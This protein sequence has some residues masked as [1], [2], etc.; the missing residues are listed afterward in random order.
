MRRTFPDFVRRY[1][2]EDAGAVAALLRE[3][4]RFHG[5]RLPGRAA[6][7][8]TLAEIGRRIR[9]VVGLRRGRIVGCAIFGF[10]FSTF[11]GKPT[12]HIEDLVVRR[13]HRGRGMGTR[14]FRALE[15]E[16]RRRGCGRLEWTVSARN[17]RALRFYA[18]RGGRPVPGCI[19]CRIEF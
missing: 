6:L 18:A 1:R 16:A 14:L 15:E 11:L 19:P 13:G 7:G 17:R 3:M 12:L 2:P 10:T 9:A 8:R 5:A 4:A